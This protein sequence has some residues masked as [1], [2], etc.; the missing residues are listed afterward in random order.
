M[1]NFASYYHKFE[2][3]WFSSLSTQETNASTRQY[4]NGSIKWKLRMQLASSPMTLENPAKYMLA[5]A[6]S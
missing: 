4:N 2:L 6:F 5:V 3:C 1:K